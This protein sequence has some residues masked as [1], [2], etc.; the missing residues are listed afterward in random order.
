[1]T[2][3]TNSGLAMATKFASF[4]RRSMTTRMLFLPVDVG[5]AIMKSRVRSSQTRF[6]IG[7]GN[8]G[9]FYDL[10]DTTLPDPI[11]HI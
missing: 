5:S 7:S 1:M 8:G 3:T 2:E 10:T 6:E 11:F 4:V 9:S